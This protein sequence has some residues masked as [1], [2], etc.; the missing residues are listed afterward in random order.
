M[1]VKVYIKE[2]KYRLFFICFSFIINLITLYGN[3]EQVVF[4]I[5]QHQTSN[6]PHFIATNLPEVFLCLIKFSVYLALYFTF[7]LILIQLWLF[8]IPALYNYEY[9]IVKK[10]LITSFLF[11]TVSNIAIYKIL[12]PYCW[13]FFSGFELNYERNAIS[14]CLETRLHEY[15]NFFT[16]IFFS[17]N[18]I[19]SLCLIISLF[20]LKFPI[21]FLTQI[22]KIIYFLS[23][24]LA[25]VLTPPDI[26]SQIFI[27]IN[28]IV[29]YEFFL[30]SLLLTNEYKK[31]E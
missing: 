29:I 1:K 23:F 13:K 10:F 3:K 6:F 31:G 5:G 16:E 18:I 26:T 22:R 12:L 21:N 8:L 28:L 14:V 27:G 30:F 25:T 15:L 7:P 19:L 17:L 4:L 9:K 2:I 20:L 11:Y 24:I